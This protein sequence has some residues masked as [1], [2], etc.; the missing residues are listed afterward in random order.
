MRS[1]VSMQSLSNPTFWQ[2][3]PERQEN[4]MEGP[5]LKAVGALAVYGFAIYGLSQWWRSMYQEG[6]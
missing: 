5:V 6:R 4:P 1:C 2:T 3:D